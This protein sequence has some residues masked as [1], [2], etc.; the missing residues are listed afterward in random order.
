MGKMCSVIN[1]RL[2]KLFNNSAIRADIIAA[3]W[4]AQVPGP[5]SREREKS[6]PG[7]ERPGWAK[8]GRGQ[9]RRQKECR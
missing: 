1:L 4:P 7:G 3:V 6:E 9:E 2:T 5:Q 8:E